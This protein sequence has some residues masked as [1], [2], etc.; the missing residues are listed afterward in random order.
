[1][2]NGTPVIGFRRGSVPEIIEDGVTGY[3]VD[4]TDAA[5]AVL[6]RALKLDR[7]A[8]RRRFEKRFSVKRMGRDYVALYDEALRRRSVDALVLAHTIP[9]SARDAA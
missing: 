7:R 2:A 3:I 5:V 4:N 1:M 9:Q 6:P 8:V